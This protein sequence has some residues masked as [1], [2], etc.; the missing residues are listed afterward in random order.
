MSHL[1]PAHPSAPR[2]AVRVVAVALSAALTVL[3]AAVA[4]AVSLP[5]EPTRLL[6]ARS[7]GLSAYVLL[8]LL[9]LGGLLLAHPWAARLRRPSKAVRLRLHASL[10]IATLALTGVHVLMWAT[11]SAGG[12]GWS[13]ALVPWGSAYRPVHVSLGVLGLYAALLAGVTAAMAGRLTTGRLWWPVHK[14]ALVSLLL[15]WV[16]VLGGYDADPLLGWHVGLGVL[17]VAVALSRYLAATPRDQVERLSAE[18]A[19]EL[20]VP[21]TSRARYRACR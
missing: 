10:A 17:V 1:R 5:Q 12:V 7:A 9:V 21:S 19:R 4:L 18:G 11:W 15:V 14:L 3:G 16:H 8:V 20:A 13:G 6:L 2:P